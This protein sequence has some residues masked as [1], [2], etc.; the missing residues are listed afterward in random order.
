MVGVW[1]Y[2]AM[3]MTIKYYLWSKLCNMGIYVAFPEK[4]YI[5]Q[6]QICMFCSLNP[7]M[8]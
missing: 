3:Q 7:F 8:S 4:N 2:V 5:K 1:I 6:K